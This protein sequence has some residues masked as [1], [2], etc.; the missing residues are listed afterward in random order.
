MFRIARI[1]K[2]SAGAAQ[3]WRIRSPVRYTYECMY[4]DNRGGGEGEGGPSGF[5]V[6]L[7]LYI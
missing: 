6:F 4:T 2:E 3:W 5:S 7:S 1:E